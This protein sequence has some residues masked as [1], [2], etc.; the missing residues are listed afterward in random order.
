MKYVYFLKAMEAAD[1][2]PGPAKPEQEHIDPVVKSE[3]QNMATEIIFCFLRKASLLLVGYFIC[4]FNFSLTLPLLTICSLVWLE[5]NKSK[6][7]NRITSKS[8]A[9]SMTKKDILKVV[10]EL[11]SWVT[12]PDRE[13]ADWLNEIILQLW[14][15]INNCIIKHF[16]G[17][18]Q[19]KMRKKFESFRFEAVD[20]GEMPPKIDGVKVYNR[21][22]TKDSIIIDFD[23]YYDGDCDI[24]F[25]MSGAQIGRL[26]DFQLA[27]ELRVVLKP[28]TIKMP[29]IGGI[30]LFFLNTPDIHFELEGISSI[31]GFSYF[32]RQ[33]IEHRITKKI[34]FPNKITKRFLKSVEAAELKSQE[35]EGVLRV[36]VFEA[37]NLERK[38]VTGKSDP[39]VILNVGAQ[40][41]KTHVVKRELNP[42]WD[43]WCEFI[44]LDPVAQHMQFMVFDQ[45]DLNED[46]FLGNG[47]V[48]INTVIKE[49]EN[50]KWFTLDNAK[51]GK[52]HMRFTWLGL[53]SD[54]SKLGAAYQ[55]TKLLKVADISTALLTVYV[56]CA[57]NLPTVKAFKKPDPY[58]ILTVG[59]NQ[60]KSKVKKHTTDPV[61]EEGFSLLIPNPETNA[62]F[63]S[64]I[65]KQTDIKM[66]QLVYHM[67]NLSDFPDLQLSKE[68]FPLSV[69]GKIIV[70]LQLRI[71]TNE[72]FEDD[73]SD[74][75]SDEDLIRHNSLRA[76]TSNRVSS[77][78]TNSSSKSFPV[79]EAKEVMEQ[80]VVEHV[81]ASSH[82]V[83]KSPSFRVKP[84]L[85]QMELTLFYS[86]ARQKLV[87]TVHK[88]TNLLLKDA[89]DI[90]DP[91][92]KLK[93]ITPET[94]SIKHK[95]KVITDN[96]D[97]VFEETF[98][99]LLTQTELSRSKLILT[100]KSK[101]MFFNSNII[102]QVIINFRTFH[103]LEEPYREWFELAEARDSD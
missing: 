29:I 45:D 86:E 80:S 49:N 89:S 51:H 67:K 20:F 81:Q 30:Q 21:T 5:I 10:D 72:F 88:I 64:I 43:Y 55:E 25:S 54:Y 12:F 31:P 34:V 68:E 76:S 19:T 53:S 85:G 97:P 65:D 4:Y 61:W 35:P 8:R 48:E 103:D 24:N 37:K 7:I 2:P 42:K 9:S 73:D 26:K 100:V 98:E 18:L 59:R 93:L 63:I 28:L 57:M 79:Q 95:T 41:C 56:D 1:N 71:L 83:R 3:K 70:S 77:S 44:I 15:S 69:A 6:K 66:D 17:H 32:I 13:R 22:T 87:V 96:C 11:P 23:I 16:R 90:P 94:H 47:V 60:L 39:Y 40:E 74:T 62:L 102:G 84:D 52:V 82:T 38:D 50:D 36:H 101:K 78:S 58:V 99:Y 27:A 91:Y 33:K 46:D 14:P 92:V 75:D